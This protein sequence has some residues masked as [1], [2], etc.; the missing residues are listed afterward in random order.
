MNNNEHE[1]YFSHLSIDFCQ[2]IKHTIKHVFN[3]YL[4]YINLNRIIIFTEIKTFVIKLAWN[5]LAPKKV[6]L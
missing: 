6:F 5:Y 2:L 4:Y 3:G 1:T